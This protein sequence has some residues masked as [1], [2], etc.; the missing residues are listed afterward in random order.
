VTPSKG[1]FINEETKSFELKTE[2]K[3]RNLN[4]HSP[5]SSLTVASNEKHTFNSTSK[6][7]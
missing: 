7:Q 1:S 3:S 2:V 6:K 4:Q 5:P